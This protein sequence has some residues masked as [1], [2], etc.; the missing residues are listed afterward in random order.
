[1]RSNPEES[2]IV[3][4]CQKGEKCSEITKSALSIITVTAKLHGSLYAIHKK[5]ISVDYE[6]DM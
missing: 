3:C 1:M 6:P 5:L 4:L 2:K